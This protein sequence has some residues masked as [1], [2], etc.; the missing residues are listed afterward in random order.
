MLIA[1]LKDSSQKIRISAVEYASNL[2][3]VPGAEVL[4]EACVYADK[5]VR[6]MGLSLL[7]PYPTE[8]RVPEILLFEAMLTSGLK[9]TEAHQ[10]RVLKEMQTWLEPGGRDDVPQFRT[11]QLTQWW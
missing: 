4:K 7:A 8:R 9:T 5:E 11:M 3:E 2:E 10:Q 1:A 6:Q